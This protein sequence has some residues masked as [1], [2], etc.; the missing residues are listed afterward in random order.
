MIMAMAM[1]EACRWFISVQ[2]QRS[3]SQRGRKM[4][5]CTSH[6]SRTGDLPRIHGSPSPLFSLSITVQSRFNHGSIPDPQ[7]HLKLTHKYR[8]PN[9]FRSGNLLT[10]QQ[11][12]TSRSP[13]HINS[14]PPPLAE[15]QC[16][17]P[18]GDSKKKETHLRTYRL[19][20]RTLRGY[21]HPS[22]MGRSKKPPFPDWLKFRG[23]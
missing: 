21:V 11:I 18:H 15:N 20:G 10:G 8:H 22:P 7:D 6:V 1:D 3:E 2:P 17:D 16:S 9:P 5:Q 19:C 4:N 23:G 13:R 12:C 14:P